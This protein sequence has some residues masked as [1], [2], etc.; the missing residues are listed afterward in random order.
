M[1]EKLQKREACLRS[2]AN[3]LFIKWHD[4]K[5][6][7]IISTMHT[8]EFVDVPRRYKK[9]EIIQKPACVH[10]YNKLMDA[11]DKTD[12]VISTIQSTKKQ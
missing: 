5:D 1:N 3:I 7:F 9:Q 10:D 4:K 6:V 12:M 8:K 2:S 11:V